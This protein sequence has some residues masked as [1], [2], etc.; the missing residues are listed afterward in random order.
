MAGVIQVSGY[1]GKG[2]NWC[3]LIVVRMVLGRP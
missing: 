2:L 1:I 3:V